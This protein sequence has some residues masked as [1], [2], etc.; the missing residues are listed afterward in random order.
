MPNAFDY[1]LCFK[2]C[3]HK[4]PEPTNDGTALLRICV[5]MVVPAHPPCIDAICDIEGIEKNV[6]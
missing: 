5:R 4:R 1:L 6:L 2:L 3:Q